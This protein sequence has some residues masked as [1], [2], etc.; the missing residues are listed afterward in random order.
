MHLQ[1][2]FTPLNI[3][4]YIYAIL[5][6]PTYR[7]KYKE[8]LKIDFPRIPYPDNPE[9]FWDMVKHGSKLRELHLL[10]SEDF[11]GVKNLITKFPISGSN[12]VETINNKSFIVD[13]KNTSMGKIYINKEQYFADV[14]LEAW[15]FF[16]GGYQP[17]QKWLKDRKNM[18][19]SHDDILHYQ[20]IILSLYKTTEVMSNIDN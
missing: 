7:E 15:E 12:I 10:E 13:D 20:K 14:P 9:E 11:A 2:S 1:N 18:V 3:L 19:L 6:S 4:D 8:F 5:H 17:A 16:I